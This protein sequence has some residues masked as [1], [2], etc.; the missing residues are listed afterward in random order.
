MGKNQALH[1]LDEIAKLTGCTLV[2]NGNHLIKDVADLES[3]TNEDASFLSNPRYEQAMGRSSAGVIFIHPEVKRPEGRNYLLTNDPTLAFQTLVNHFF[4]GAAEKS[5]FMGVHPTA[6]IHESAKIGAQATIGPY[7]I[8]DKGVVLGDRVTIS[9][10]S[11]IG[12]HTTIGNDTFIHPHVTV[13]ERCTIGSR[14]IL[15]PGAVIG[16][17]GFGY[18]SDKLGKHHKLDQVGTVTIQ[19]DVEI[20]ANTTIDRSRFKTTLIGRGSKIDNLVMIGHGVRVGEDNMIVSQTGIA[21]STETG[22]NVILGG[23][24]G[25]AG[26]IK[27]ADNIMIAASSGVSKSLQKSGKY[28]GIPAVPLE[29]YN[30]NAVLLRN[31]E[32]LVARVKELEQKIKS[33][34]AE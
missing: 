7:A 1:T 23:Q 27:L 25:L 22:R 9:S 5:G 30:R 29:E 3:A 31:M 19:D 12:P 16:S 18:F 26:H 13:R 11:Y 4:K 6:V 17:C 21:G 14:V 20:G 2:G 24:V 15:Q 33:L 34:K 8:I 32:S 28:G 10:G